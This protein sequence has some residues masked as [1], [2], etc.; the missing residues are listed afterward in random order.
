MIAEHIE[1]RALESLH[2]AA[3]DA[4]KTALGLRTE[5]IGGALASIA[6]ALPASAIAVNRVLGLG[7]HE[8]TR[9]E[10]ID[11]I[12]TTYAQAGAGRYFV[13][14]HPE[15]RPNA[16]P[17]W[18]SLLGL[19]KTRGWMKFER[20]RERPPDAPTDLRVEKIGPEHGAA[21]GRIAADAFDLGAEAAALLARLPEQPGWHVY[22]SFDGDAPAGTGTMFVDD[23]VAWFDWGAT[24]PEAR[25]RGSQS[26]IMRRRVL[27][28][29]DLGVARMFTCTGEAVPGDPQHSYSNIL[30]AGFKERYVRENYAPPKT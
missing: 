17:N 19:E 11:H 16:L 23:G 25:R 5:T 15:A 13:H 27:D 24:A 18:F 14:H 21:F 29:L 3:D 12:A 26:A 8:P 28:A 4:L 6:G 7:L 2:A 22:L 9:S 30:R 10:W 1:R 20:G